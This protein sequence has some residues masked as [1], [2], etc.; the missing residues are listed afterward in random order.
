[1]VSKVDLMFALKEMADDG[2]LDRIAKAKPQSAELVGQV[3]ELVAG[4]EVSMAV[5]MHVL[6][7][8]E[9]LCASLLFYLDD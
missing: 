4:G 3:K 8:H 1:M 6:F 2:E 9:P 5:L 7:E